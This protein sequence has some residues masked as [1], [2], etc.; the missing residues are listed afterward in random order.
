MIDSNSVRDSLVAVV[1]LLMAKEIVTL[2]ELETVKEM[3]SKK[4][5]EEELKL[6]ESDP[7]AKMLHTL[8]KNGME[9]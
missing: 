8:V 5:E 1:T 3:A 7:L 4:R 9:E 2:E 6:I